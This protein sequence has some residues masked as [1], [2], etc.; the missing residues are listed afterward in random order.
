MADP[1]D[2]LEA[3]TT[4]G[5]RTFA[6]TFVIMWTP[7]QSEAS[8]TVE[9]KAAGSLLTHN[10]FSPDGA[11]QQVSGGNDTYK[12]DGTLVA[13]FNA[14]G[15]SGTLIGQKLSFTAPKGTFVFSG[16]IGVW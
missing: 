6:E 5:S 8:L 1:T 2:L 9:V 10:T 3:P 15:T 12:F 7:S 11:T 14:T 16:V 13:A 4:S